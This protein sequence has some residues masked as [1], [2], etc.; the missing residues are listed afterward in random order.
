MSLDIAQPTHGAQFGV[1]KVLGKS[2]AILGR[3]FLPFAMIALVVQ[4]PTLLVQLYLDPNLNT[5]PASGAAPD[6][7]AT[8]AYIGG[9]VLVSAVVAGLTTATLVYGSFQDLRG[10]K[11]GLGECFSRAIAVLPIIAIGA[12]CYGLLV[13]LGMLL[14]VIPGIIIAVVYWLYVPAIVV[15]KMSL[16]AALNRSSEL[17]RGRRWSIF[18]IL[19]LVALVS[20]GVEIAVG[21]GAALLGALSSVETIVIA[22]YALNAIIG[23]FVSVANAVTYYYLRADSEG[24]DIEDIARLFD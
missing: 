4:L 9:L 15:E 7:G 17:T 24:V 2:L 23:A 1:G 19:L 13:G 6:V 16:G 21:L 3:N 18:A 22:S 5:D 14:L 11:V 12:V 10:Q 8:F 20:I